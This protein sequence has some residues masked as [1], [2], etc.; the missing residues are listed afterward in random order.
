MG[1][2]GRGDWAEAVG[3]EG[4]VGRMGWLGRGSRD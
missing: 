1:W 4:G 3:I 2:G